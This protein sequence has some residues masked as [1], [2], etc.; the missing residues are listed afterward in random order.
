M[1]AVMQE[2]RAPSS[3]V[4]LLSM[5]VQLRDST[6]PDDMKTLQKALSAALA[7]HCAAL[8]DALTDAAPAFGIEGSG[9]LGESP[10]R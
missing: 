9:G 8:A 4:A 10:A 6:P 2:M 1:Q 7:Q 5:R 3:T